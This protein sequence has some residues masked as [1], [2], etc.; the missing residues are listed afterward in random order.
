MFWFLGN[1]D[2]CVRLLIFDFYLIPCVCLLFLFLRI[3]LHRDPLLC[4]PPLSACEPLFVSI[5][6]STKTYWMLK[7]DACPD[8]AVFFI[9]QAKIKQH[10]LRKG[11]MGRTVSAWRCLIFFRSKPRNHWRLTNQMNCKAG[12]T[13]QRCVGQSLLLYVI[14]RKKFVPLVFATFQERWHQLRAHIK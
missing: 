7:I 12:C 2:P 14:L 5:C 10:W 8:Y 4:S 9:S 3:A 1:L 13:S 6:K 11:K